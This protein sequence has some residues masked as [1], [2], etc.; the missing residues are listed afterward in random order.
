MRNAVSSRETR[1]GDSE[2]TMATVQAV[3]ADASRSDGTPAAVPYRISPSVSTL[4]GGAWLTGLRPR[5]SMTRQPAASIWALMASARAQSRR[6]R[7]STRSRTRWEIS[8]GGP[9]GEVSSL[10]SG[11]IAGRRQTAGRAPCHFRRADVR[12]WPALLLPLDYSQP[13]LPKERR[14]LGECGSRRTLVDDASAP[15][16]TL[17]SLR[18]G[19]LPALPGDRR[20]T[21]LHRVLRFGRPLR[22]TPAVAGRAAGAGNRGR[23]RPGRGRG[24]AG[25][26]A[27]DSAP[28][29][30][31][32]ARPDAGPRPF[33]GPRLS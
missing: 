27:A 33:R 13:H 17:A 32:P 26:R 3:V 9:A 22:P 12:R 15:A 1:S 24:A 8:A 7:A 5:R 16:Y 31:Q 10:T 20:R 14:L 11:R 23:R 29:E 28:A 4:A 2:A 30:G 6:A 19:P 18:L 25:I 21:G